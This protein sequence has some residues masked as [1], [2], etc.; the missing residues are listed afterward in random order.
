MSG[1][2]GPRASPQRRLVSRRSRHLSIAGAEEPLL[3]ELAV[4]VDMQVAAQFVA[5]GVELEWWLG[6]LELEL[7]ETLLSQLAANALDTVGA[8]ATYSCYT[9]PSSEEDIFDKRGNDEHQDN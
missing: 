1:C 6:P 3:R 7:L 2:A 5:A 8:K 4:E 9:S